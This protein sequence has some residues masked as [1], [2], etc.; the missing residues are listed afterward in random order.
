MLK[1]VWENLQIALRPAWQRPE[2]VGLY[3]AVAAQA[4]QPALYR[5]GGVPDT[6]DGR[7]DLLALH[8]ALVLCR[9][10]GQGRAAE[11]MRQHLFDF[12]AADMDRN[13]RELGVGDTGISRRI[14]TMGQAFYGRMAAY[15]AALAPARPRDALMTAL[16][17]NLYGTVPTAPESLG[18]MADYTLRLRDFL[19][20]QALGSILKGNMIFFVMEQG[21]DR[22]SASQ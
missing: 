5:Q 7:F 6:L 16:D 10:R 18:W 3:S 11:V 14:K 20:Q 9:L 12:L 22:S 19:D 13:L 4:R 1:R 2:V 17:K 8:L 21:N 15:D